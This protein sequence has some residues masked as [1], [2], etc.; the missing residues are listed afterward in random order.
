MPR[1]TC[2]L[3][4]FSGPS[5]TH[6]LTAFSCRARTSAHSVLLLMKDCDDNTTVVGMTG[7]SE[8]IIKS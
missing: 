6:H 3:T 5:L 1:S 8:A 7:K 4:Y 2:R